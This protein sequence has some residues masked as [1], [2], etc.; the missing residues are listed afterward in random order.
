MSARVAQ[1]PSENSFM[2]RRPT[3]EATGAQ[4]SLTFPSPSQSGIHQTEG[5]WGGPETCESPSFDRC[6]FR[7]WFPMRTRGTWRLTA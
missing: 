2:P 6:L 1:A 3:I 4:A 5:P 7:V